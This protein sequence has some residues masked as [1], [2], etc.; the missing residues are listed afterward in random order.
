MN[1]RA[2]SL[3]SHAI[4]K[5][6][7]VSAVSHHPSLCVRRGRGDTFASTASIIFL[8]KDSV[9]SEIL[10]GCKGRSASLKMIRVAARHLQSP[11]N[12][13][14]CRSKGRICFFQDVSVGCS[15]PAEADHRVYDVM[16]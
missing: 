5:V 11:S 4:V 10:L 1:R 16:V 12:R 3:A 14:F 8:V 15:T 7:E 13:T 6:A 2:F 9:I